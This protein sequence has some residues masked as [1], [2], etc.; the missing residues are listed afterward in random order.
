MSRLCDYGSD[1]TGA[2]APYHA[3]QEIR[4]YLIRQN[5]VLH[6][7]DLS[8]NNLT[9]NGQDFQAI[10]ALAGAIRTHQ[11][12]RRINLSFVTLCGKGYGGQGEYNST[13]IDALTR[14]FRANTSLT[15]IN[16][17]YNEVR[18]GPNRQ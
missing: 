16:V 4:T 1:C 17:L 10:T 14:A 2:D 15:S 11:S 9:K 6:T 3:L 13:G 5:N 12:L 8:K 18:H 7:L